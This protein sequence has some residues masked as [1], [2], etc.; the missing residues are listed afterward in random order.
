MRRFDMR[1]FLICLVLLVFMVPAHGKKIFPLPEVIKPFRVYVDE[2]N[3]YIGDGASILI[4]SKKNGQLQKKFGKAGEG[5]QEFKL[6]PEFS[7]ELDI[8]EGILVNSVA[9]ISYFSKD[10]EFKWEKKSPGYARENFNRLWDQKII[11][12]RIAR[13]GDILF[14]TMSIYDL[15]FSNP[16]VFHRHEY[17]F[18]RTRYNPIQ[19][20]IYMSN[21]YVSHGKIYVAGAI[22]SGQ[23]HVYNREGKNIKVL[24]PP[25]EKVPFTEK[26]K[27]SWIDSFTSNDEYKRQYERLK[28]FFDYPE[29]F[30][31][32]Q[33]FIVADNR[34]YIQTY[35]RNEKL[36]TNEFFVLNLDGTLIKKRWLPLVEFWDF[37]PNP[38]TINEGR[39][40]QVVED[41]ETEEWEL[42]IISIK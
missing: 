23:I 8:Q 30:P 3:I 37:T 41:P 1:F 36:G 20:G 38:Y 7:P 31:L 22:D 5:P 34:I 26:D 35:K 16:R 9:R 33:N 24:R 14:L 40:Y 27:Q 28:N 32:F 13:D 18:Q 19:R 25:L 15:D 29:F 11:G 39:L 4:L 17:Y 6:Y 2:K 12:Q 42:H 21:F 10:G